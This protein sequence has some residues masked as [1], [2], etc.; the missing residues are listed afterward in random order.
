[1][2]RRYFSQTLIVSII[3]MLVLSISAGIIIGYFSVKERWTV[4][5]P[6]FIALVLSLMTILIFT[7]KKYKSSKR[8]AIFKYKLKF[9]GKF[10]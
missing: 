8:V 6:V 9:S 3:V 4:S 1:M 5:V 7:R 2:K 10:K